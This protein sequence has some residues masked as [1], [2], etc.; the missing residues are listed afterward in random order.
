MI[1]R[2]SKFFLFIID[3]VLFAISPLMTKYFFAFGFKMFQAYLHLFPAP[4]FKEAVRWYLQLFLD[5]NKLLQTISLLYSFSEYSL[6]MMCQ[7]SAIWKSIKVLY[8]ESS[9]YKMRAESWISINSG[10]KHMFY[11]SVWEIQLKWKL[12]KSGEICGMW[13][14][15]QR[16][17]R[18]T[19]G[20]LIF[21]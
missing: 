8:L 5:S 15:R 14:S 4:D 7:E 21:V 10:K 18:C 20:K 6:S 2:L 19:Y 9:K 3:A 12:S 1:L 16:R 17:E 13:S 11:N